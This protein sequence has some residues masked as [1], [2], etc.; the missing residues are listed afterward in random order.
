MIEIFVGYDPREAAVMHVL[1][2]SLLETSTVPFSFIPLSMKQLGSFDGQ[3]DGTNQFVY[4][5]FLVPYLKDYDGWAVYMDSDMMLR[6]D[7]LELID[8][9][10]DSKAV[11]VVKHAYETTATRK[12][13]G[14]PMEADNEHYPRKNWSSLILWNCGHKKNRELTPEFV[15][16][17]G[18]K[19]LHRFSWLRDR[20]IGEIPSEWNHLVGE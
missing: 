18:G 17:A 19:V 7:I 15:S 13:V 6:R 20:E 12:F 10:D 16:K 8:M 5:R 1:E 4:S 14:T 3:K 2:Q 11:M 9:L